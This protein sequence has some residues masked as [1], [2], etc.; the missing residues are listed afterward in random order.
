MIVKR[1]RIHQMTLCKLVVHGPYYHEF[2]KLSCQKGRNK[3]YTEPSM[4]IYAY[5]KKLAPG[6]KGNLFIKQ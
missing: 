3:V 6:W 2:P 1:K 5:T 4:I